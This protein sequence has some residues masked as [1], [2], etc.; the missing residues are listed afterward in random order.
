MPT[1]TTSTAAINAE[2]AMNTLRVWTM[3]RIY[4]RD[5][6]CVLSATR[7]R[8]ED[9]RVMPGHRAPMLRD[10]AMGYRCFDSFSRKDEAIIRAV[11]ASLSA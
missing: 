7:P 6:I 1:T 5:V 9:W 3:E 11:Q 8:M 2:A 10:V 4:F